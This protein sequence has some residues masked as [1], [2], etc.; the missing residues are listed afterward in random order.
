MGQSIMCIQEFKIGP[1]VRSVGVAHPHQHLATLWIV[2]MILRETHKHLW[3]VIPFA[4]LG[5]Y[6][7]G[8]GLSGGLPKDMSL[9]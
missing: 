9:G 1:G 3:K 4:D 8:S 2:P 5:I 6:D 7:V